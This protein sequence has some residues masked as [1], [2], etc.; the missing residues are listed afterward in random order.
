MFSRDD[1]R[2]QLS[3]L[4]YRDVPDEILGKFVERL[5]GAQALQQQSA[6]AA[7]VEAEP[8]IPEQSS[9]LYPNASIETQPEIR[10]R[11]V[12]KNKTTEHWSFSYRIGTSQVKNSQRTRSST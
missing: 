4:G 9:D 11:Q 3:L 5:R 6:A 2:K 10:R 12:K 7:S 1:V 8:G